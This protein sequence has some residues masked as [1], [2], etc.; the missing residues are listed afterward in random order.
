GYEITSVSRP[1]ML[2]DFDRFDLII[3]MDHQNRRDLKSLAP[4]AAAARKVSLM[5]SY[6]PWLDLQEVP[7]PY[8]GGAEG[9]GKVLDLLEEA[10]AGLLKSLHAD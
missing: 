6:A 8:Y 10:C 1:V 2:E 3:A 7:D 4:D 5:L 9:F